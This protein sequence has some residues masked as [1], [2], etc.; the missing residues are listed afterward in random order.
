MDP[1]MGDSLECL[2]WDCLESE[3][4]Q[5]LCIGA[6]G[7]GGGG[8]QQHCV[9][10]SSSPDAGSNS[11]AATAGAGSIG[12]RP[13]SSIVATER[14]RRRRL[15]DR[16][17]ALRS[18]V[19]NITKMDKASILRDAIEYILQ[20]QQ[21]ERQLLDELGLLEA[22]AG[23]HHLLVGT[24]MP[25]AGAAEDD[26]DRA[27]HAA[28]SPTRRMKRN[29]SLST[30]APSS[31]HCPSSPPV[32]ALQVRVSGAGDKVLV[33]SVACRHRRDAVA[34]LCRALEGLRLRV[35]AANVT[36]ASG[37]VTHTALVQVRYRI[38]SP[39][40]PACPFVPL[41]SHTGVLRSCF[42][43]SWPVTSR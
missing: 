4:L 3:A 37:T 38:A 24:P 12:S 6:D 31:R 32:D 35:I 5:S 21:L 26:D 9:G 34:K 11:S 28:V 1:T 29:P 43:I 16:L 19:P 22:G 39:P 14:R 18:V 23:A 10:Y 27:G 15:N 20:L 13:G 40:V 33:V 25:S 7:D 36:A 17:Y 30:P 41:P 8:G 2:L 42:P